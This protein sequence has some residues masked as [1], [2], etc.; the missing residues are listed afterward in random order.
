MISS[1]ANAGT[2]V[3]VMTIANV[4]VTSISWSCGGTWTTGPTLVS[5]FYYSIFTNTGSTGGCT[6]LTANFSGLDTAAII[7]IVQIPPPAVGAT[8]TVDQFSSV[9]DSS[10]CGTSGSPCAMAP[11]NSTNSNAL[12]SND[13]VVQFGD[14]HSGSITSCDPSVSGVSSGCFNS[15][16]SPY[17]TDY[18]GDAVALN[19][20]AGN[21]TGTALGYNG[22]AG[23]ITPFFL[24]AAFKSSLGNFTVT[25]S[26]I[27]SP[28]N[29]NVYYYNA[30]TCSSTCALTVP[31]TTGS[32][33]LLLCSQSTSAAGA[34]AYISSV[35]DNKS[36]SWTDL[37]GFRKGKA[38]YGT[39]D[40]QYVLSD[41][42]GVTTITPTMNASGAYYFFG[43]YEIHKSSGSIT[44]DTS[45]ATDNSGSSTSTPTGQALTLTGNDDFCIQG[46]QMP[47]A[48]SGLYAVTNIPWPYDAYTNT[49]GQNY[50]GANTAGAIGLVWNTTSMPAP[51]WLTY[52]SV[53]AG[54]L[55]GAA[56]WK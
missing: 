36:E 9:N 17:Q 45:A 48:T 56:C 16:S 19:V 40:C 35:S 8:I 55:V 6:S 49:N 27:W 21:L 42:A 28:T 50:S 41:T 25:P 33:L 54:S 23:G 47:G 52:G 43:V 51:T 46:I 14:S 39:E 31:S 26:A 44:L 24:A 2:A 32:D 13:A 1:V 4:S 11:F 29:A 3:Q 34:S 53:A 38:S 12:T 30:V 15:Y 7:N 18:N 5:G 10:S 22:G 20:G 37:S